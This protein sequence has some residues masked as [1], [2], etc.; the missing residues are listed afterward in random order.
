MAYLVCE[1]C[2]GYYELQ[3][4]ESPED[5]DLCPC[6]GKLVL[7]NSLLDQDSKNSQNTLKCYSC[8]EIN[9]EESK[10][11]LSCGKKIIKKN[12]INKKTSIKNLDYR[13]L[14]TG[15]FI[16][17][18]GLIIFNILFN[19]IG[20]SFVFFLE[21][22]QTDLSTYQ[23]IYCVIIVLI[24]TL[25][26]LLINKDYKT[27][28]L[29]SSI[30]LIIPVIYGLT[31]FYSDKISILI[32][33]YDYVG[34]ITDS[35]LII[36]LLPLLFVSYIIL[37]IFSGF[38]GAFINNKIDLNNNNKWLNFKNKIFLN[39]KISLK[40]YKAGFLTFLFTIISLSLLNILG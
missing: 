21:N 25:S 1:N 12:K 14:F 36:I 4:G 15:S 30:I 9:P 5:F 22:N 11:C 32:S 10:F 29:Y 39:N 31:S 18:F 6:G 34:V 19:D 2:K 17:F 40:E 13:I 23:L 24:G 20:N 33:V 8:G 26:S 7:M 37:G 38:L 27:S 16:A 28:S 35:T 3:S